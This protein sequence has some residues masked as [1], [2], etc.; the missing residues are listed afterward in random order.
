MHTYF[1]IVRFA[2]RTSHNNFEGEDDDDDLCIQIHTYKCKNLQLL[3]HVQ[4]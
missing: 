1:K 4:L 3:A 2:I